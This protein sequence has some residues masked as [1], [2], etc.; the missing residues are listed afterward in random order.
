MSDV[1][2]TYFC[3]RCGGKNELQLPAPIAPDFSHTD[4]TCKHCGDGTRVMLSHCPNPSCTHFVYWI[5]DISIPELV[6]G[7]AKYMTTNMQA[8]IDRAAIQGAN[9]SI[10]TTDKFT[11]P[12]G[13]PCGARFE[14]E[15]P[16]PDLD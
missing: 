16:I 14:I 9:I 4:L 11:V 12:A 13:C 5:N 6:K 2:F 1:G 8:M 10:D 15:I 7:F 3:Y